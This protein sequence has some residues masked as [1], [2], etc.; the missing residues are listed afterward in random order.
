MTRRRA[1]FLA[2]MRRT[3]A[4]E[5]APLASHPAPSM[6]SL[7]VISVAITILVLCT[8]FTAEIVLQHL[9]IATL[10]S[11]FVVAEPASPAYVYNVMLIGIPITG[12]ILGTV[13]LAVFSVFGGRGEHPADPGEVALAAGTAPAAPTQAPA[14]SGQ[15]LAMN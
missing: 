12:A 2:P 9:G 15:G 4:A 10:I 7:L 1:T 6:T 14:R 13:F 8:L 5:L 11:A 3:P